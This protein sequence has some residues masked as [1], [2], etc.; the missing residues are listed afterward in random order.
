MSAAQYYSNSTPPE[1]DSDLR[2]STP[3]QVPPNPT[4]S[5]DTSYDS[6]R[7]SASESYAQQQQQQPLAN[8]A[9]GMKY[10]KQEVKSRGVEDDEGEDVYA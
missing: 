4:H 9:N 3:Y 1:F 10:E 7:S 5:V 6:Y 2:K 8:G